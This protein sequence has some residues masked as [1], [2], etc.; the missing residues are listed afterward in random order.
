VFDDAKEHCRQS[1]ASL[2]DS[3]QQHR[4]IHPAV[5]LLVVFDKVNQI[6]VFAAGYSQCIA[7]KEATDILMVLF[8]IKN[9]LLMKEDAEGALLAVD[10]AHVDALL[11][12]RINRW[13]VS[14]LYRCVVGQAKEGGSSNKSSDARMILLQSYV[15]LLDSVNQ[16]KQT[17][18]VVVT[19]QE[20]TLLNKLPFD[21][22]Y[23]IINFCGLAQPQ[24]MRYVVEP[25]DD[26]QGCVIA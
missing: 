25:D 2:N 13:F 12:Y 10:S 5:A 3:W 23:R 4:N 11:Q 19:A 6:Y 7:V 20:T 26:K 22:L 17:N 15:L 8:Y 21:C 9:L 1:A 14:T 18:A 24:P 16:Q